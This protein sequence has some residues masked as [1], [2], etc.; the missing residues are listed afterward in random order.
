MSCKK[1][2][3]LALALTL[4][5]SLLPAAALAAEDQPQ[6]GVLTYTEPIKPQ[7]EDAQ[8]FSED[9][10]A[11]KQN[12][13]WGYIDTD[14][15]VVIPFEYDLAYEFNEGKAIVGTSPRQETFGAGT[16]WEETT[17]YYEM[18]FIDKAGKYTPFMAIARDEYG[19]R[20]GGTEQLEAPIYD[21]RE[22]LLFH[23]GFAVIDIGLF[24]SDGSQVD[25]LD[26]RGE[27]VREYYPI[28]PVNEGLVPVSMLQ[29]VG[30]D[31]YGWV[32]TNGNIV[33]FFE[34]DSDPDNPVSYARTFNQGLAP[35]WV[36]RYNEATGESIELCGFVDRSFR[37]VIQPGYTKIMVRNPNAKYEVF[38]DIGA[39]LVQNT[40]GKWGGIDKTGRTVLPFRYDGLYSYSQGL[41]ACKE[42]G[43]WGYIDENGQMA[44][45]AQ[46]VTASTFGSN[47][48]T[49]VY[50]GVKAFLIDKAGKE[51]PGA[52]KLAPSTYF[53]WDDDDIPTVYI[54]DEYVVIEENGKY[55][56]G[57]IEYLPPLPERDEMSDWAYEE[58][59]AAIEENLVPIYLQSL[60]RSNIKRGEF[61]DLTM[62][63]VTE[64]LGVDT[65]E[66]V[67]Q[68]TGKALSAWFEEYPFSDCANSNVIA[69]YALGIVSGRG[70]GTFDP[71]ATITRQ[72]AATLLT[73]G[74]KALGMDTT[75]ITQASFADSDAVANWAKN[76]VDFVAQI[77]VMNGTNEGKFAP[78]G[79]YS[80]EQSFMTIYK[81]YQA[82][83]ETQ[84]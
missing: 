6:R 75:V 77:H 7:Y 35:V 4:A 36:S 65:E 27:W 24:R 5:L 44:I 26:D 60:Y 25:M 83:L 84:K 3:S 8:L 29:V 16:E 2:L 61:C 48:Y 21:S 39:A 41:A 30:F 57:H 13:K 28:G 81:L 43:K 18:G 42:N 9:L 34:D 10:A 52:D 49:V 53:V 67:Q 69:A 79:T 50:D 37:W 59:T 82:L 15:K 72:E 38:G 56:Y 62:Q 73:N 78:A 40:A 20:T 51:I 58:V 80:R 64:I 11:V 1:A 17:T 32:D 66:L 19:E 55:G 31:L 45:P 46:Y 68:R 54:P 33:K 47:G 22:A 71:Y 74:A 23:N 70:D 63:A 76:S 14:N 12:G